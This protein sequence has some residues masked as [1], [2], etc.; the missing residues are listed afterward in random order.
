L[1]DHVQK[2]YGQAL[3]IC[4]VEQA[5]RLILPQDTRDLYRNVLIPWAHQPNRDMY[6]YRTAKELNPDAFDVENQL[7][8]WL[9]GSTLLKLVSSLQDH[10]HANG[11]PTVFNAGPYARWALIKS[12]FM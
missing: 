12:H 9:S 11:G 3:Q 8:K 4:T 5:D 7:D 2:D 10:I 6:L 1:N